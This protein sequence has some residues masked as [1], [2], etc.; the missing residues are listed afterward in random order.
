M[1]AKLFLLVC[2]ASS[3]TVYSQTTPIPDLSFENYLETHNASGNIDTYPNTMGDGIMGNA[4]V[5][6]AKI[7]TVTSLNVINLGINQLTGIEDFSALVVLNCQDNNLGTLDVSQNLDLQTLVCQDNQITNLNLGTIPN[8]SQ[9][10]CGNNQLTSIDI[11]PFINL[12]WLEINDNPGLSSLDVSGNSILQRID[13]SNSPIGSIDF[14]ANPFQWF[15]RYIY[16]NNCDLT[17]LNVSTLADLTVLELS[18][19]SIT[20]LDLTANTNQFQRLICDNNSLTTLN[21][22]N[23]RNSFVTEA[24][25]SAVGNSLTCI[26]VDNV[27]Y[28]DANWNNIDAGVMFSTDCSLGVEDKAVLNFRVYPNPFNDE[29]NINSKTEGTVQVYNLIGKEVFSRRVHSLNTKLDLSNLS[30]GLYVI[31][32]ESDEGAIYTQKLVKQ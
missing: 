7:N 20:Q 15:V 9:L 16:L 19:N 32:L 24:N 13:A 26:T 31:K 23:G 22:K 4:L 2:L 14:T 28:S 17:E 29:L 21:V 3:Y 18:D 27:A 1:K 5:E 25:F 11:T 10:F 8:L 12:T 30:S 6:T